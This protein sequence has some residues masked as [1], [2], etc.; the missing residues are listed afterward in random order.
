MP[1]RFLKKDYREST[2]G[3]MPKHWFDLHAHTHI[4]PDDVFE[5]GALLCNM[6]TENL[7]KC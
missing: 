5:Q 6:L 3:G 4:A 2:K 7:R 1:W